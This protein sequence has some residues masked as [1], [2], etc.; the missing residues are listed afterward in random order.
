[1]N[2]HSSADLAI[3]LAQKA[4][5]DYVDV[6]I[7]NE[8]ENEVAMRNRAIYNVQSNLHNSIGIRVFINGFCG[9]ASTLSMENS[10]I[11]RVVE[12]AIVC[13]QKLAKNHPDH[14]THLADATSR[15]TSISDEFKHHPQHLDPTM[16]I[17]ILN[18]TTSKILDHFKEIDVLDLKLLENHIQKVFINSEGSKIEQILIRSSLFIGSVISDIDNNKKVRTVAYGGTGGLEQF[19]TSNYNQFI[20]NF[21]KSLPGLLQATQFKTQRLPAV[22]NEDM[23]WNICHEFC[24]T[25]EADLILSDQ[26]PMGEQ[27]GNKVGSN[28]VTIVDDASVN[29][30]GQYYFDDEGIKAS[31][32]LLVEDGILFDILQSRETAGKMNV[33]PTSNSRAQ[34]PLFPPLVRQ[35]NTFF[36][37]GDYSFEELLE[38]V[39][40][41]IFICD[42]FG[43]NA[44]SLHGQFQLDAQFGRLIENGKLTD[45]VTGFSI[46]G[47]LYKF[48][49]KI[50]GMSKNLLGFPGIC[51][52]NDQKVKVGS[53]SPKI[54]LEPIQLISTIPSKIFDRY[55][56]I[57]KRE[58]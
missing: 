42:S 12:N 6:R 25:L 31:G 43:G 21:I 13:A 10:A 4:G 45:Y 29:G 17:N 57:N 48:L 34:N 56:I 22:L 5:A 38:K 16:R 27:F 52:K 39:D 1:M 3:D 53:I 35:S 2:V 36:E 30:F 11:K 54:A 26:S 23:G 51:G 14:Q 8:F 9:F 47:N 20:S 50:N 58:K 40:N 46:V 44:D 49:G 41:G 19:E 18:L 32:T 37:P 15:K 28:E 55:K 24:H 33:I 7:E